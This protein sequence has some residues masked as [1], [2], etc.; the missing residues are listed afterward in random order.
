M[1][2]NFYRHAGGK[3]IKIDN[4]NVVQALGLLVASAIG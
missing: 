1:E 4:N 2:N 3:N